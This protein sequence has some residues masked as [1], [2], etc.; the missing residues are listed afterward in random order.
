MIKYLEHAQ[1]DIKKWDHCIDH[2]LNGIIYAYSWYLDI[3]AGKWD[4]L[5]Y[6]DYEAVMPLP[7]KK[8][9]GVKY[10]YQPFFIQQLGVFSQNSISDTL[11]KEF[12]YAFPPDIKF[13]DYAFNTYNRLS[14]FDQ[15]E[16][17]PRPTLQLDLIES[18]ESLAAQYNANTRR[19]I[20]KAQKSGLFVTQ[21]VK[22]ERIIQA[23]RQNKGKQIPELKESQYKTLNQLVY[24]A[25]HKG[26]AEMLGAYTANNTLSAGI[27]VFQSHNKII[28][29]FSGAEPN[30]RENGAMFILFD[31]LIG[32]N[33]SR[34][35]VLDFEGSKDPKLARFYGGFGAKEYVFLQLRWLRWPGLFKPLAR[36]YLQI[37]SA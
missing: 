11:I 9:W 16:I 34:P 35:L 36:C 33:A 12:L 10:V 37:R 4:A 7:V 30:S 8:K 17:H 19:N 28:F 20:K 3:A 2:A 21:D 18:Y 23:F 27:I 29:L 26:R 24:T 1:I 5:V 31:T 32:Q 25:F 14:D 22:P 6:G 15:A 13:A